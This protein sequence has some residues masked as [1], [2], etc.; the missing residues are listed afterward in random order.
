[1][2][3]FG[4]AEHVATSGGKLLF[5]WQSD[6]SDVV[7]GKGDPPRCQI[8][9]VAAMDVV[10]EIKIAAQDCRVSREAGERVTCVENEPPPLHA[11][12]NRKKHTSGASSMTSIPLATKLLKA[13]EHCLA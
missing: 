8:K 11:F 13:L 5:A 3:R 7:L 2:L 1:M 6:K 12:R 4:T 9:K 10:V